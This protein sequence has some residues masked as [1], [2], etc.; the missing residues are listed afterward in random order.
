MRIAEQYIKQCT[1]LIEKHS[2]TSK[3][4]GIALLIIAASLAISTLINFT[5]IFA[6]ILA[7]AGYEILNRSTN[8][9]VAKQLITIFTKCFGNAQA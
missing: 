9:D 6:A 5:I 1:S 3:I 7:F 8:G 2:T 4:V